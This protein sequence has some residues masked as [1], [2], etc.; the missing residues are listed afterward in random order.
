M[1]VFIVWYDER[2]FLANERRATSEERHP[3]AQNVTTHTIAWVRGPEARVVQ[4]A[5]GT[6]RLAYQHITT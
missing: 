6:H 3:G 4:C 2:S 1:S 5:N